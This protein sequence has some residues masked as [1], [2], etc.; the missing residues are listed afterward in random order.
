MCFF[1][2]LFLGGGLRF[3]FFFSF[4]AEEASSRFPSFNVCFT[5]VRACLLPGVLSAVPR[6]EETP[7]QADE[8]TDQATQGTPLWPAMHV[9][10]LFGQQCTYR[11]FLAS[12]ARIGPFWPFLARLSLLLARSTLTVALRS[13][14]CPSTAHCTYTRCALRVARREK[15]TTNSE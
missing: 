6:A 14:L 11:P 15:W 8:E 2:C 3:V 9:S 13:S 4:Q 5:S 1:V 7:R 12:N 10:A